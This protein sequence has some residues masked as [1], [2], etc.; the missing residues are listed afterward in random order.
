MDNRLA[1]EIW[2]ICYYDWRVDVNFDLIEFGTLE[3]IAAAVDTEA[4][5]NAEEVSIY[6]AVLE[7]IEDYI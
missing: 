6:H 4:C 1:Q 5:G 7:S 3:E 2:E